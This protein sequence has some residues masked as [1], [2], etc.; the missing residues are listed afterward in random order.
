MGWGDVCW[1]NWG[2]RV[3]IDGVGDKYQT[4]LIALGSGIEEGKEPSKAVTFLTLSTPFPSPFFSFLCYSDR[5]YTAVS[6]ATIS[7]YTAPL[8]LFRM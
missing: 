6:Y 8:C 7:R 1:M 2:D 5:L 4:V 3:G